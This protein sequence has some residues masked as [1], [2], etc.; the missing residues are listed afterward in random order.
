MPPVNDNLASARVITANVSYTGETT[1]GATNEGSGPGSED[2][3]YDDVAVWYRMEWGATGKWRVKVTNAGNTYYP[4]YDLYSSFGSRIYDPTTD[5]PGSIAD[6]AESFYEGGNP[7]SPYV[8]GNGGGYLGG[9]DTAQTGEHTTGHVMYLRFGAA[10]SSGFPLY[11]W[12]GTYDIEFEFIAP[13]YN[14]GSTP[15]NDNMEDAIILSIPSGTTAGT[16]HGATE[17]SGSV[18]YRWEP[19]VDT[20]ITVTIEGTEANGWM[21]YADMYHLDGADPPTGYGDLSIDGWYQWLGDVDRVTGQP[22]NPGYA[23]FSLEGGKVYLMEVYD[24]RFIHNSAFTIKTEVKA[25]SNDRIENATIIS[26]STDWPQVITDTTLYGSQDYDEVI[27]WDGSMTPSVWYMLDNQGP[28]AMHVIIESLTAGW[29]VQFETY[30]KTSDHTQAGVTGMDQLTQ[31]GFRTSKD[32]HL[33][34]L[35]LT[36]YGMFYGLETLNPADGDYH[37]DPLVGG[38][39][40]YIRVLGYNWGGQYDVGNFKL[41]VFVAPP[42]VCL[43]AI[44]YLNPASTTASIVS[45]NV[46]ETQFI[47]QAPGDMPTQGYSGW[48]DEQVATLT[49][50]GGDIADSPGMYSVTIKHK[51][52]PLAWHWVVGFRR[53]GQPFEP[54]AAILTISTTTPVTEWLTMTAGAPHPNELDILRF[55]PVQPGDEIEV[56]CSYNN[57]TNNFGAGTVMDVYQVCFQRMHNAVEGA[58][59]AQLTIPDFPLGTVS[60][61]MGTNDQQGDLM[62][63][64]DT[65]PTYTSHR[66][67][68]ADVIVT[69]DG[70]LWCL[71]SW[72]CDSFTGNRIG[73]VLQKWTGSAWSIVNDDIGGFGVKRPFGTNSLLDGATLSMDTDGEDIWVVYGFDAGILGPGLNHSFHLKVRKY[74]VSADT[75]S[76]VGSPFYG[77]RADVG[78]PTLIQEYTVSV[79]GDWGDIPIIRVSPTG[80]PWVVFTDAMSPASSP[81]NLQ[82]WQMRHYVARWTGST[83]DVALLPGPYESND[84]Y[85]IHTVQAESCTLGA[86]A[87]STTYLGVSCVEDTQTALTNDTISFTPP[88]GKWCFKSR[89]AKDWVSGGSMGSELRLYKNGNAVGGGGSSNYIGGTSTNTVD[90]DWTRYGAFNNVWVDCNGSDVISVRMKVNGTGVG[91]AY[92]DEVVYMDAHRVKENEGFG[93]NARFVDDGQPQAMLYMHQVGEVGLGENPGV[94]YMTTYTRPFLTIAERDA[95]TPPLGW[96]SM[97][98]VNDATD[99]YD[100]MVLPAETQGNYLWNWQTWIYAEWNGSEWVKKWNQL[101]EENAQDHVYVTTL[102]DAIAS[103]PPVGHFQQGFGGST[104]GIDNYMTANLGGGQ[105]FG[106]FG[107]TIVSLKIGPDGFVPFTDGPPAALQGPGYPQGTV[108]GLS[109]FSGWGWS[110][111]G[112]SI[113]VDINGNV[114]LAWNGTEGAANNYSDFVAV[115]GKDGDL[116][117]N[118]GLSGWYAAAG[119]NESM[120]NDNTHMPIGH[121]ISSPNGNKVYVLFDSFLWTDNV[122]PSDPY[123]FGVYECDVTQDAHVPLIVILGRLIA[124]NW[125]YGRQSNKIVLRP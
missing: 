77:A 121:V 86:T 116:P 120:G 111:G 55:L 58:P 38:E 101:I 64:K 54:G 93:F 12:T 34:Y 61:D 117:G 79:A 84:D 99:N 10:Q 63:Y 20:V 47:P 95:A 14:P 98:A 60:A 104:D 124:M 50:P 113:H 26:P 31:D 5:P 59:Y 13:P 75:W 28:G 45:G 35:D 82:F 41:T 52:T 27:N 109:G 94:L 72:S 123:T 40:F 53:N 43:N 68:N 17:A 97:E 22:I 37:W 51:N 70:T 19:V 32:T 88:A 102:Y 100:S 108:M 23:S 30:Y 80:V 57:Y 83:W 103:S 8:I 33:G 66:Y 36:N 76:D 65:A 89:V 24:Y 91:H 78:S 105:G 49:I 11:Q 29:D 56:I 110:T 73:P 67:T 90:V 21:P 106:F 1:V 7:R 125:H 85:T 3:N 4:S 92:L 9:Y 44:D 39:K 107:D 25:P 6:L 18:W 42:A 122:L 16:T 71:A 46:R 114:W 74:D 81:E 48:I 87:S 2:Y 69:N 96:A 119:E 112:R 15:A 62:I 115:A 118:V